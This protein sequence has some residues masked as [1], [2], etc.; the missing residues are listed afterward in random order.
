MPTSITIRDIPDEVYEK[1]KKQADLH[2]R[3]VNSEVVYYLK[4]MVSSHRPTP[5]D[6]IS[7]AEK[8]KSGA[9]KSLSIDE[10][11]EAINAGRK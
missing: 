5:D 2:H 7:R 4:Q 10:I 6:I 1:L 8:L 9:T 11:K 3:S